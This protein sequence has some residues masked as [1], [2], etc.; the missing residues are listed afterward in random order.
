M[1]E[2]LLLADRVVV[3]AQGQI[4]ADAT[5]REMIAGLAGPGADPLIAI[6]RKQAER[7]GRLAQ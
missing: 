7:L 6:P 1:A 3:M 5:P 2:A 4:V